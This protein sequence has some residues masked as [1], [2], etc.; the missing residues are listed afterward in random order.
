MAKKYSKGE[1]QNLKTQKEN[2]EEK[3]ALCQA[4]I[5]EI[6]AKIDRLREAY[7]KLDDAKETIDVIKSNQKNMINTELFQSIWSGSQAQYFYDLCDSGELY[8]A[9]NGYVSNIDDVEDGINWEINKL[10]E[11]KYEKYGILTGL[12]NAWDDLCT[13]IHNYFN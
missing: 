5:D 6:D 4:E 13:R 3:Q 9:Y 2:N 1:Y 10:N 11:R 12:I 8:S 7:D